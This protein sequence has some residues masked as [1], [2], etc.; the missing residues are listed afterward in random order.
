MKRQYDMASILQFFSERSPSKAAASKSSEGPPR[1]DDALFE[2]WLDARLRELYADVLAEEIPAEMI[3][4]AS[5]AS[6]LP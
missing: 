1:A 6:K 4:V 2:E 3:A 5:K